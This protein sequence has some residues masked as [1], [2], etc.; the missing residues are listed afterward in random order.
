M[1]DPKHCLLLSSRWQCPLG[2]VSHLAFFFA[3]PWPWP[4]VKRCTDPPVHL[5]ELPY[6]PEDLAERYT[7]MFAHTHTGERDHMVVGFYNVQ[8][9][10]AQNHLGSQLCRR[11]GIA[12]HM[13]VTRVPWVETGGWKQEVASPTS[14]SVRDI[15]SKE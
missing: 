13:P 2:H 4:G 9:L 1:P 8:S 14:G 5:P 10:L 15:V 3:R 7:C 12:A 6:L 11:P